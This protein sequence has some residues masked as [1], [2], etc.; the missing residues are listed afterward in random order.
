MQSVLNKV[1]VR[2]WF[3]ATDQPKMLIKGETLSKC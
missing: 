3:I 1:G 2:L